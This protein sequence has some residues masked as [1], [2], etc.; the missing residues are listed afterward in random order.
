M[1]L[2]DDTWCHHHRG[3][4]V[5]P[6]VFCK[7]NRPISDT[8]DN[9]EKWTFG[10]SLI[11]IFVIKM[12]I[13]V[14]MTGATIGRAGSRTSGW[15]LTIKVGLIVLLYYNDNFEE[16]KKTCISSSFLFEQ[17][18][19][20]TGPAWKLSLT[21]SVIT[22]NW[23]IWEINRAAGSSSYCGKMGILIHWEILEDKTRQSLHVFKPIFRPTAVLQKKSFLGEVTRQTFK[24]TWKLSLISNAGQTNCYC[25]WKI[26][27]PADWLW[28]ICM[29]W[30]IAEPSLHIGLWS[31][32]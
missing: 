3:K 26:W 14:I 30:T 10:S 21:L 16:G 20:Q 29:Y 6:I 11:I 23:M 18:W 19:S 4:A 2:Y 28:L 12:T 27:N 24:P 15:F 1:Y 13:Q 5:F 7:K 32:A 17:K 31:A 8:S 22:K 9:T 25:P